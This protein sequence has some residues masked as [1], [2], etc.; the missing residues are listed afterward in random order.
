MEKMKL[1]LT[2]FAPCIDRKENMGNN[3]VEREGSAHFCIL[4]ILLHENAEG[5]CENLPMSSL[6]RASTSAQMISS[7]I[8][9]PK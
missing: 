4:G 1:E 8:V 3:K 7:E 2:K 9:S 6:L 5:V